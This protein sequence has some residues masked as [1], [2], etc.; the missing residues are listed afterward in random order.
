MKQFEHYEP[1]QVEEIE[2]EIENGFAVSVGS[3]SVDGWNGVNLSG[4]AIEQ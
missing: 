3:V 2:V 1:P 4:E